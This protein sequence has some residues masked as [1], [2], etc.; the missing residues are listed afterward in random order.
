[1]RELRRDGGGTGSER[2]RRGCSAE[3]LSAVR[4]ADTGGRYRYREMCWQ[5][6]LAAA[7]VGSRARR[8][9]STHRRQQK[10]AEAVR[11]Y[12]CW[13]RQREGS[14]A[15]GLNGVRRAG[16][17]SNRSAVKN[18][19]RSDAM[20]RRALHVGDRAWSS[21]R[22]RAASISPAE[23][24]PAQHHPFLHFV[25]ARVR[26]DKSLL[27]RLSNLATTCTYCHV[28]LLDDAPMASSRYEV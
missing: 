22:S 3:T 14:R 25:R 20:A 26:C 27:W 13:R 21:T 28:R 11:T 17:C 12:G 10:R 6:V 1:V 5:A 7:V 2:G 8:C 18:R 24:R 16:C 4:A 15:S 9:R 23:T 19:E